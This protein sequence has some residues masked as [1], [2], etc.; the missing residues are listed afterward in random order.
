MI[1]RCQ[2][3]GV[4]CG[5]QFPGQRIGGAGGTL[6]RTEKSGSDGEASA[7]NAGDPGSIP[8]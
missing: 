4:G 1:G 3:G 7:Y 2:R 8:V 6:S 5:A